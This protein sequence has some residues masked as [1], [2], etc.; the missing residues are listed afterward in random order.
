MHG[1]EYLTLSPTKFQKAGHPRCGT[2]SHHPPRMVH[3][4]CSG[5]HGLASG[6]G[7][8]ETVRFGVSWDCICVLGRALTASLLT[9]DEHN[10]P[11]PGGLAISSVYK[12]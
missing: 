1:I 2:L 4:A 6:P 7:H 8:V 11:V 10:G 5:R 12:K 9:A 3:D